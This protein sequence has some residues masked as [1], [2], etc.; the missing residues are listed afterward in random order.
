VS[1]QRQAEWLIARYRRFRIDDRMIRESPRIIRA[2]QSKTSGNGGACREC[3]AR[4][5]NQREE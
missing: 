4:H 5:Q 1:S 2:G 3:A